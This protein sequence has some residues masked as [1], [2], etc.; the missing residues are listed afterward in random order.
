MHQTNVIFVIISII[1]YFISKHFLRY[2]IGF[3][4]ECNSSEPYLWNGCH[5]L[6]QKTMNFTDVATVSVKG[7]DY[8]IHF[9]YMRK[10]YAISMMNNFDLNNKR[11]VP[12]LFLLYI[13]IYKNERMQFY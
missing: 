12:Y 13:Y 3:K 9:W 7:S 10:D 1:K 2:F 8:R 6:L 4:H 5:G 11:S